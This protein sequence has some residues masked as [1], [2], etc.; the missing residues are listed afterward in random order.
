MRKENETSAVNY[1]LYRYFCSGEF[2]EGTSTNNTTQDNSTAGFVART[3]MCASFIIRFSKTQVLMV[4]KCALGRRG[5]TDSAPG[6]SDARQSVST[7]DGK[8]PIG[9]VAIRSNI[10]RCELRRQRQH[11]VVQS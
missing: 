4:G 2:D 9:E 1:F 5:A 10:R 8:R 3:L 6:G 11:E 7:V